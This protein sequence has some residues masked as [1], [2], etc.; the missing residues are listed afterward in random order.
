MHYLGRYTHR[1]AISNSRILCMDENTVT[2]RIKDYKNGGGWKELTL[3]SVEFIRI[4]HY[5]ILSNSQKRK[6][7]PICRNLI[8]CREFLRR[9]KK[10]DNVQAVKILYKKDVTVCPC[11]GEK[12]SYEVC[13][14]QNRRRSSA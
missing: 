11:C 9:F 1:I 7:I 3:D 5:G 14:S 12:M 4:R 6:L 2:I 13:D 8:G 10:D